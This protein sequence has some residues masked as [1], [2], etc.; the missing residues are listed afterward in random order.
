M[1]IE[2]ACG[3]HSVHAV[4]KVTVVLVGHNLKIN[5]IVAYHIAY[6]YRVSVSQ[7]QLPYLYVYQGRDKLVLLVHCIY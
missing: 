7:S 1:N 2:Y 6:R 4:V 5:F 3:S